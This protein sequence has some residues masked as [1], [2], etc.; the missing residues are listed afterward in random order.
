[1]FWNISTKFFYACAHFMAE[2]IWVFL[3]GKPPASSHLWLVK[4]FGP[5]L[6]LQN[7]QRG[8]RSS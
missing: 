6:A 8:L 3:Q 5:W 2:D 7:R 4:G 1:V